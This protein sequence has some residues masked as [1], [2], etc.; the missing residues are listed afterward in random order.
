MFTKTYHGH[1]F[2]LGWLIA[3]LVLIFAV[4]FWVF[5]HALTVHW[6]LAFIIGLA[7]AILL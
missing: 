3:L 1:E 6:I 5:G 4:G 7:L 2:S